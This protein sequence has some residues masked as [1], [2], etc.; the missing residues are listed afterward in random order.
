MSQRAQPWVP[1]AALPINKKG[2]RATETL[3]TTQPGVQLSRV[4]LHSLAGSKHATL[5]VPGD[6]GVVSLADK[7]NT[8]HAM[9][10]RFVYRIS[11][12]AHM[13]A[14]PCGGEVRH[15]VTS[16]VSRETSLNKHVTPHLHWE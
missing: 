13:H 12:R 7:T 8:L 10:L 11:S 6:A 16:G 3:G 14:T 4:C 5:D 1:I 2:A 15:G 9:Q